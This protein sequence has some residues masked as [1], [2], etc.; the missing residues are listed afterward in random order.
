VTG[1][2]A[3]VSFAESTLVQIVKAL[4]IFGFVL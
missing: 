4:V 3:D 1:V 2:L